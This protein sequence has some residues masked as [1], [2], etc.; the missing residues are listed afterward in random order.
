MPLTPTHFTASS[1]LPYAGKPAVV[2]YEPDTDLR[3]TE[4]ISL[5]EDANIEAFLRREVLCSVGLSAP[6][7]VLTL[8]PETMAWAIDLVAP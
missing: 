2:E 7:M 6:T 4:Q 5:Q 8:I 1:K 3:D